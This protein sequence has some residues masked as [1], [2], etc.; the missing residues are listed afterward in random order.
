MVNAALHGELAGVPYATEP[1]F[2]LS[3]PQRCPGVPSE[4]LSPRNAWKDP[5]AYDA[6]ARQL[7]DLFAANF[8][9]LGASGATD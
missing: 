9:R 4:V 6:A 7:A 8:N 2:G 1:V 5:A 3:V